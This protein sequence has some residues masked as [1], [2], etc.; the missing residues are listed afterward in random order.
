[1]SVGA[2]YVHAMCR[3]TRKSSHIGPAEV[4]EEEEQISQRLLAAAVTCLVAFWQGVSV[5]APVRA[6]P[7]MG[8]PVPGLCVPPR[9][10]EVR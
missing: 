7:S 9:Q 2:A 3:R 10:K 1:M 4:S 6:A 8:T 5:R